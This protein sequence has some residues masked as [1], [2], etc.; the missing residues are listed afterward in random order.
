MKLLRIVPT[1]SLAVVAGVAA[2][3]IL[4]DPPL[5]FPYSDPP[6]GPPVADVVLTVGSLEMSGQVVDADGT[7][8]DGAGVSTMSGD[9]P[10][11]TWTGA[12]GRFVLRELEG[13]P[14]RV[15]VTALGFQATGFDVELTP[16]GAR[17]DVLVVE[18]RVP[19]LPDPP[20][21]EMRGLSGMVD[22]SP[23][24]KPQ[25]GYE[26]LLLPTTPPDEL[27]GGFPR[28]VPVE[29]D[30]SFDAPLLHV[31]EYRAI[32]LAPIDRGA[33]G[34]DL[35]SGLEGEPRLFRHGVDDES[36]RLTLESAAGAVRGRVL[37]PGPWTSAGEPGPP[38]AVRGGLVRIERFVDEP[39]RTV[40][41]AQDEFRATRT[42]ERGRYAFAD[43]PP[44]RYR[45]TVVAGRNR[46]QR[47]VT[48][49]RR[50]IVD[51]DFETSQ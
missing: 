34:P 46:R 22:F 43:L 5:D 20:G 6:P 10:Q 3:A 13:G 38:R 40:A 24:S 29:P 35:L 21:L 19:A 26:L 2:F 25:D 15:L 7:P 18:R 47:E 1:A 23:L 42:D 17:P 9:R 48:V 36:T 39:N 44:G 37:G 28:R 30:G 11:W 31:G 8:L 33:K 51:V 50:E 12:D 16:S 27:E 45:V 41:V 32:L 14:K 4:S 49:P